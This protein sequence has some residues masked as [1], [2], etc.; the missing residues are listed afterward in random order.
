MSASR[1]NP[2]LASGVSS[3]PSTDYAAIEPQS[4]TDGQYDEQGRDMDYDPDLTDDPDE[5]ED[6]EDYAPGADDEEEDYF[7]LEDGE[8]SLL[9]IYFVRTRLTPLKTKM[10]I[11]VIKLRMTMMT[12]VLIF[13]SISQT[14]QAQEKETPA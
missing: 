5:D 6:D 1:T 4:E 3:S 10:K 9:V 11:P 12:K 13:S 7:S 14:P 2:S 8:I